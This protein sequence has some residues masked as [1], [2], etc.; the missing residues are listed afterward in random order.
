MTN[1]Q[2]F[3]IIE[4]LVVLAII[5]LLGTLAAVAVG[6]ARER[7]RDYKRL[8]DVNEIQI[9]LE[10]Y[11]NENNEYPLGANLPLGDAAQSTCLSDNG[12]AASCTGEGIVFMPIVPQLYDK[13]LK[14]L[15][16][17]GTP[18][19]TA[20][21]YSLLENGISYAISVEFERDIPE[22]GIAK[23]LNCAV[24]TGIR[25]GACVTE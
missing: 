24:P 21:C 6:S 20:Y 13:G 15:S 9:A 5:G 22:R 3:S 23:G 10:Q 17:C 2:G 4:L 14:D 8:N 19:R 12:F 11:F 7:S 25:A 16:Q 1:K 18:A